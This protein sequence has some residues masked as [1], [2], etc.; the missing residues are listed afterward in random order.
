VEKS[1]DAATLLVAFSAASPLSPG[2]AAA[3][4]RALPQALRVECHGADRF[5]ADGPGP[6]AGEPRT[7]A[8]AADAAKIRDRAAP[9][10]RCRPSD[11]LKPEEIEALADYIYSPVPRRR[12]WGEARSAP[13]AWSP[14]P[15]AARQAAFA[16]DPMN[17]FIVVEAGDHHVTLLDGDKLEPHPPLPLALRAARRAEVHA[18]RPLRLLRLARRLDLQVRHL[19][20]EGGRRGA[21][22]HQHAQRRRVRRR[23]A[24]CRW[25]TTCRTRWCARRRPESLKVMTC[26]TRTGRRASRVSA[27]YDAEPR[28]SFVA[29]LKDVRK[30]WEISYDPKAARRFPPA[31]STTSSTSEGAFVPGF[32]N[33]RRTISTTTSTTSSSPRLQRGDGRQPGRPA[34]ARWCTS[35]CA[36]SIADVDLPGMPHLGSGITWTGRAGAA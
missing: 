1:A 31:T 36:A 15:A 6:A 16:A 8:Q 4:P 9:R 33:P 3:A 25:P 28:K 27:V 17:L 29:A 18:G 21:R 20:P 19:E 2:R 34:R 5:G 13:R 22:R 24:T 12:S 35:T 30:L 7:P 23:Q 11:K 26:A 10:R 32:L 14:R